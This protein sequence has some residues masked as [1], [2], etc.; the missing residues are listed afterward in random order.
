M[1][2]RKKVLLA[3]LIGGVALTTA[4]IAPPAHSQDT[5]NL[6]EFLSGTIVPL[7][8]KMKDLNS[9]YRRIAVKGDDAMSTWMQMMGGGQFPDMGI[10][11]TKGETI[12]LGGETYL[13][14]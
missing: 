1:Q 11:Y 9:D 2:R 3:V 12:D 14:S 6:K 10:Y 8:L 5:A 4:I 7:T 13:I